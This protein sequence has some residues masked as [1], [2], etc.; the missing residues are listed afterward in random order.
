MQTLFNALAE[1]GTINTV[2]LAEGV[3]NMKNAFRESEQKVGEFVNTLKKSTKFR[4]VIS[5]LQNITSEMDKMFQRDEDGELINADNLEQA[6]MAIFQTF[7]EMGKGFNDLVIGPIDQQTL[8]TTRKKFDDQVTALENGNAEQ[9]EMAKQMRANGF[10]AFLISELYE[11]NTELLEDQ[12]RKVEEQLKLANN[13]VGT[14]KV[15]LSIL[16][17]QETAVKAFSKQNDAAAKIQANLANDQLNVTG[18]RMRAEAAIQEGLLT[19][20]T[21][22]KVKKGRYSSHKSVKRRRTR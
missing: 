15:R 17:S 2:T 5:E 20:E 13:L 10:Q 19:E 6:K 21:L 9:R 14:E 11:G 4:T 16:K 1:E 7:G 8:E 18:D 3:E 12:V 22:N